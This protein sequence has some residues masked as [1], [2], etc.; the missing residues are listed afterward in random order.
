MKT[1]AVTGLGVVSGYGH[2]VEPFWE[3][4]LADDGGS[5]R[6]FSIGG[7]VYRGRTI[8]ARCV[9]PTRDS[10]SGE[11]I[12]GFA[13]AFAQHRAEMLPEWS[14]P[15]QFDHFYRLT[16]NTSAEWIPSDAVIR[17]GDDLRPPS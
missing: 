11:V 4:R 6:T 9:V 1:V 7:V 14:P 5:P 3:D 16:I 8:C 10:H 13:K 2:G 17:V 15:E 12:P